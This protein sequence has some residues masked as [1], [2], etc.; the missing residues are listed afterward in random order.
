MTLT[1]TKRFQTRH[2]HVLCTVLVPGP[3]LKDKNDN[4]R[5]PARAIVDERL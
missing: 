3:I 1:Y 5:S 2:V 4:G